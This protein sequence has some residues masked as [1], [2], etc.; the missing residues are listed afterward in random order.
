MIKKLASLAL[1]LI[2]CLSLCVPA[3]AVTAEPR[4]NPFKYVYE[5]DASWR[6]TATGTISAEQAKSQREVTDFLSGKV[7]DL[8]GSGDSSGVVNACVTE[9]VKHAF[10][11]VPGGVAGNFRISYKY[12][13]QYSIDLRTGVRRLENQWMLSEFKLYQNGTCVDTYNAEVHMH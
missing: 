8:V 4:N 10:A 2:M 6:G 12:K 11:Q 13:Y 9:Y 7:G 1:A 5:T 3:F